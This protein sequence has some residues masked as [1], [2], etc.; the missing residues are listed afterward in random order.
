V[1]ILWV[2]VVICLAIALRCIYLLRASRNLAVNAA[3]GLDEE[4]EN[5]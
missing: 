5:Q 2:T 4:G 3:L 1:I